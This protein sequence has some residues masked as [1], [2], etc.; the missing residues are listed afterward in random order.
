[1]SK[2]E[3]K[4]LEKITKD[5]EKSI[6]IPRY[7]DLEETTK[8]FLNI[9]RIYD[10]EAKVK[11]LRGHSKRRVIEFKIKDHN[12]TIN[13]CESQIEK[14]KISPGLFND[15]SG[16]LAEITHR[17]ADMLRI[18]LSVPKSKITK[19]YL[20]IYPKEYKK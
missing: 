4:S 13:L 15:A 19:S 20:K 3:H 17:D 7:L 18:Y 2:K 11:Y 14:N 9:A 16:Y 6:T 1:M 8:R 5:L 12:Y 10:E